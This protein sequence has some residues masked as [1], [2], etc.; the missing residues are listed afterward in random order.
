MM[1]RTILALHAAGFE[2]AGRRRRTVAVSAVAGIL[3][4]RRHQRDDR[5]DLD[6]DGDATA[7]R[8]GVDRA[9]L[10]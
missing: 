9:T 7:T 8:T 3:A 2:R 6:H 4:R 1:P 5:D 10:R